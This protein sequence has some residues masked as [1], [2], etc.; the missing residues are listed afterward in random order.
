MIT[1]YKENVVKPRRCGDPAEDKRLELI[2]RMEQPFLVCGVDQMKDFM[3]KTGPDAKQIRTL[4]RTD[5][6]SLAGFVLEIR[7]ALK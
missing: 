1:C 3:D 4:D 5:E 6:V 7:Q 2:K